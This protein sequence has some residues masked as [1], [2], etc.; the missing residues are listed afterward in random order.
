MALQ[1]T[2]T[3]YTARSVDVQELIRKLVQQVNAATGAEYSPSVVY[4]DYE[5]GV[6]ESSYLYRALTQ[7]SKEKTL[8]DKDTILERL[9]ESGVGQHQPNESSVFIDDGDDI[10]L[11]SPDVITR[12]LNWFKSAAPD[13][14]IRDKAKDEYEQRL[15]ALYV[16]HLESTGQTFYPELQ[17]ILEN[18]FDFHGDS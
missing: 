5:W 12:S 7:M 2:W 13:K 15:L 8:W 14:S 9:P 4:L 11:E 18:Q 3:D 1:G 16:E 6:F 10:E 17:A